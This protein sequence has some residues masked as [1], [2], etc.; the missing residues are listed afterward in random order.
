M[1]PRS[2]RS[3]PHLPLD[4]D[5][6]LEARPANVPVA[7]HRVGELLDALAVDGRARDDIL[8][9]LTE[10]CANVVVHAYPGGGG[11]MEVQAQQRP[12]DLQL[13]VRDHG[14]GMRPRVDS[15]GLG[16]GLPLMMSLADDVCIRPVPGGGTEVGLGFAV[17]GERT[18]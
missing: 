16:L 6:S 13:V 1:A 2:R 9:A 14:A 10:A 3:G 15:P 4:L 7:R 18:A 5:F 12:G 17:A 11:C 8:L